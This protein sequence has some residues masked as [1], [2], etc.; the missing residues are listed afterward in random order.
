MDPLK[1]SLIFRPDVTLACPAAYPQ[2]RLSA[3]PPI[4]TTKSPFG[5]SVT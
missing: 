2:S 4:R 5:L 1:L 3:Q